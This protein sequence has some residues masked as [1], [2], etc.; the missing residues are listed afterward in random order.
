M[1]ALLINSP[2]NGRETYRSF[3]PPLGVLY[4]AAMLEREGAEVEVV[5]GDQEPTF[6][7]NLDEHLLAFKPDLIGISAMGSTFLSG[8]RIGE[9]IKKLLPGSILVFGGYHPTFNAARIL[10]KYPFI[11]LV[12][13]GEGEYTILD[14][15]RNKGMGTIAGISYRENGGIIENPERPLIDNLDELPFPARH[16]IKKYKYDY[17]STFKWSDP[18]RYRLA[19]FQRYAPVVTSRGCPFSCL[20]CS[21]TSFSKRRFRPRSPVNVVSEMEGLIKDGHDRFYFVDDNFTA[22]PKRVMEICDRILSLGVKVKWFC[23]GRVDTASDEL[24]ALMA[25]AGC[26]LIMFGMESGSQ[27][28]LDY[29]NKRITV[30]HIRKAI[31]YA[32]KSNIDVMT[33]LIIGAP[34][35]TLADIEDTLNV[36]KS[37]DIDFIEV[38][39]LAV[40]PGTPLWE[41]LVR[42]KIIDVE[43]KWEDVVFTC[44]IYDHLRPPILKRWSRHLNYSFYLRPGYIMRQMG[45]VIKNRIER[46]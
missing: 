41:E 37:E 45:R 33:S 24:Y 7:D 36:L 32:K 27:R 25:K 46:N 23:L 17:A 42:S 11:D 16:L 35:E 38:S 29:Y 30:D 5:D 40:F 2:L 15:A 43:S 31:R 14:I 22:S 19:N 44:D 6:E 13:R 8:I 21:N 39:K 1:K 4:L 18:R 26:S 28:I 20:Y 10:R 34:I 3:S 12:I 9:K